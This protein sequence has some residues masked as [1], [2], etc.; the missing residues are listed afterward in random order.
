M[1]LPLAQY[2]RGYLIGRRHQARG[3]QLLRLA[4]CLDYVEGALGLNRF[5]GLKLGVEYAEALFA[6]DPRTFIGVC[7]TLSVV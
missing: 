7:R 4:G 6:S 1:I 2:R 5:R 3:D